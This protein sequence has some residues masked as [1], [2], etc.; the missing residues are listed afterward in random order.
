M[1]YTSADLGNGIWLFLFL[2]L[3]TKHLDVRPVIPFEN[4]FALVMMD[5]P[6]LISIES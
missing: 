1:Q 2:Q 3:G 4:G 5:N 6:V